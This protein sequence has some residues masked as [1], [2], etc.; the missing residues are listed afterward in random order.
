MSVD[1]P[2]KPRRLGRLHQ[3]LRREAMTFLWHKHKIITF[4]DLAV[5]FKTDKAAVSRILEQVDH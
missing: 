4:E 3:A 2:K 1:K 5:V